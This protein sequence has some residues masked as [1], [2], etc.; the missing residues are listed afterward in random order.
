MS[1][2][3]P[4]FKIEVK[5]GKISLPE[6]KTFNLYVK[7]LY[8]GIYEMII[9]KPTK[10]KS[11]AQRKYYWGAIIRTIALETSGESNKFT[12]LE[13]HSYCKANFLPTGIES[14]EQLT[15]AEEEVYHKA[16]RIYF[17]EEYGIIIPLP[18]QVDYE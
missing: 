5:D 3:A 2:P 11:D 14:T 15:T 1:S 9:R 18:N 16:I 10:P 4:K 6:L 7:G 13:I 8:D 17:I 12:D